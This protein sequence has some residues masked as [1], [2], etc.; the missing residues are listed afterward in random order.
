ML[1]FGCSTVAPSKPTT[2]NQTKLAASEKKID[3]TLESIQSLQDAQFKN[4]SIFATGLNYSLLQDT[5]ASTPVLTAIKLNDRVLSIVGSPML[6]ESLK[7]KKIVDLL[8]SSIAAEQANGERQLKQKD[9]EIV[10][11]QRENVKLSDL[12]ATQVK[13]LTESAGKIAKTADDNKSTLDGMGGLFGL[14]AVWWGL[15]RFFTSVVTFIVVGGIIFIILRILSVFNPIAA[16]AFSIFNLIGAGAISVVKAL[17][18]DA[19]KLS[20]LVK[21][22]DHEAYK[23][24]LTKIINTVQDMKEKG[25]LLNKEYTLAEVLLQLNIEMGDSDKA[26]IDGILKSEKW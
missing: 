12:Y 19:A 11:L 24:T 13:T 20:N 17:T 26:L 5:N 14:N 10:K 3:K 25:K 8:N 6:D 21:S 22:S 1:S 4:I 9:D 18:P 2:E 7:I 16:S 15:K 23:K